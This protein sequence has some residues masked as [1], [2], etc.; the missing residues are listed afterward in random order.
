MRK[1]AYCF[2]LQRGMKVLPHCKATC[3]MVQKSVNDHQR[4]NLSVRTYS[5]QNSNEKNSHPRYMCKTTKC[6]ADL[7]FTLPEGY[8]AATVV[9]HGRLYFSKV[10]S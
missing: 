9:D 4:V 8:A 5:R 1:E 2:D 10:R 7:F 3:G 6:I